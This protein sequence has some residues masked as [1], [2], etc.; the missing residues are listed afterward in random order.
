MRLVQVF[1]MAVLGLAIA[2]CAGGDR[3]AANSS[4]A[5]EA[6]AVLEGIDWQEAATIDVRIRQRDFAPAVFGLLRDR[7]YVL[8][9][10]NEDDGR[11][12]FASRDF[13]RNVAVAS[14]S[15]ND[16]ALDATCLSS[17]GLPPGAVAEIR[18]VAVRDGRYAFDSG[19]F[20]DL[21]LGYTSG[22]GIGTIFVQ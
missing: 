3:P 13:F 17:I 8:R 18:L 7:P 22:H 5:G 2:G 6:A 15:V 16:E 9:L 10:T 1:G 20:V 4:C 14:A 21:G 19:T 12:G 11:H